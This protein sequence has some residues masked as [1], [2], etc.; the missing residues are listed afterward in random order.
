MQQGPDCSDPIRIRA[1]HLLCI[2]GFQ[3]HGY[4]H[5]FTQRMGEIITFLDSYPSQKIEIITGVDE[6]CKICPNLNE[7]QCINDHGNNIKKLDLHVINNTLLKENY[8]ITYKKA[9][10]TVNQYL[11]SDDIKIICE[12]CIWIDKCLF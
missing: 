7:K 8:R 9:I 3:G 1:H 6:I 10:D 12:G 4:D 5:E 2:Q 11:T